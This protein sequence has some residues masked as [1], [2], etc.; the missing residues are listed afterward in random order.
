MANQYSGSFEHVI[1][2]KFNCSA[3]DA[4]VNCVNEGLTYAQAEEKLGFKHGTIRKWAKRFGLRLQA[5]EP[6]QGMRQESFKKHFH[7]NTMNRYN[8]LSRQW[9]VLGMA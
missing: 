1:Q 4:L 3:K 8:F 9:L 6:S 2:N 5:G 7:E